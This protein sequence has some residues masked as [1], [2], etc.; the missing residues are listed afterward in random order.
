MRI[1]YDET[2]LLTMENALNKSGIEHIRPKL[3][4]QMPSIV[5]QR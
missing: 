1:A 2:L 3:G 4:R 5:K